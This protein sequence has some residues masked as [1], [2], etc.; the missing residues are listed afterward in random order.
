MD[1]HPYRQAMVAY[2]HVHELAPQKGFDV[3]R[4]GPL[5]LPGRKFLARIT[6]HMVA[7]GKFPKVKQ[8]W[9]LS[10]A[11][12]DALI[13]PMT[14]G[15]KVAH[16]LLSQ[17]GIHEIPWGSNRGPEIHV[18]EASTG[19]YGEPWCAS[20]R[21]WG[22]RKNG[23][24]GPVSA[25]AWDWDNFGMRVDLADAQVGDAVTFNIGDGHIGT[26]LSHT[27]TLVQTV[28]GNTSDQVAVRERPVSVIRAITRQ[29]PDPKGAS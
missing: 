26:Y 2:A 7:S 13:P 10:E 11:V 28:D 18:Y 17:V 15:E 24:T 8:S 25:R 20:F 3:G 12:R 22:C 5:L 6:A 9:V 27:K 14:F 29:F 1:T 23:Y 4:H 21:S 19:G 16:T